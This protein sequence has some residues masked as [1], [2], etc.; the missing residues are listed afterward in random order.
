MDIKSHEIVLLIPVYNCQGLLNQ[1]L[2]SL[3]EFIEMFIIIVD[4]GSKPAIK[5]PIELSK[6]KMIVLRN[7]QNIL[8]SMVINLL[9]D[10]MQET[11]LQRRDSRSN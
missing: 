1:S 10:L 9:L 7:E 2:L 8:L 5:I 3:A 4:D 11:F 6:H